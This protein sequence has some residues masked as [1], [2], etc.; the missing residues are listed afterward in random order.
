[1]LFMSEDSFLEIG[2]E[3]HIGP[4]SPEPSVRAAVTRD[5][6]PTG[7][8]A[9]LSLLKPNICFPRL[10]CYHALAMQQPATVRGR[11]T[12]LDIATF[13]CRNRQRP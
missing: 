6:L 5:V 4:L 13:A 12:L 2:P 10:S 11:C 8:I 9:P 7:S 3:F 1:M